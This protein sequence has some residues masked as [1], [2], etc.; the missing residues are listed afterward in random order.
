MS[1]VIGVSDSFLGDI[2]GPLVTW[3]TGVSK[4]PED[5]NAGIANFLAVM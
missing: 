1:L 5:V 3:P 2:Q 4:L